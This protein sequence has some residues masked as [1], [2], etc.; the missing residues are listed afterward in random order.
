MKR[1]PL[2]PL[3]GVLL[4]TFFPPLHAEQ[5]SVFPETLQQHNQRLAPWRADRYGMFIHWGLYAIPAGQWNGNTYGFAAEW[6]MDYAAIPVDQYEPLAKQFNPAGFNAGEWVQLAKDAGMKYIVIT[7][8]HHDGFCLFDSRYTDY[9][10][11]DATPFRRDIMKELADECRRQGIKIGWYYSIWDWHHPDALPRWKKDARPAAGADFRRYADYVKN[12]ITELLTKYGEISILWF[13]GGFD[14]TW[15]VEITDE[16]EAHIR[17]LAPHIIINNRIG[18]PWPKRGDYFTPERKI[19]EEGFPREDWESCMT[20]NNSWG[21]KTDDQNW[22]SPKQILQMLAECSAKGGNLLLNVG[23]DARGVIP[24]P[25]AQNLREVGLWL[26]KY[27]SSIYGTQP[28]IFSHGRWKQGFCTVVPD[29]MYLHLFDWPETRQIK[30]PSIVN[31]ITAAYL[32]ADPDKTP[33]P[34]IRQDLTHPDGAPVILSDEDRKRLGMPLEK[35]YRILINLPESA[36]D[37]LDS[38]V[39]L[40]TQGAPEASWCGKIWY[41]PNSLPPELTP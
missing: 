33:L 35:D 27:G 14:P 12:Q 36:S 6:I 15:T 31:K 39:V 19:P 13:D 5:L 8:K 10:I 30:L 2:I 21:F 41:R 28:G 1:F 38:V 17:T 11:M 7:A 9:D 20:T 34:V 3:L 16:L 4:T 22:K 40:E 25:A 23:P 37:S 29:R 32:L 26:Q 18:K 24:A